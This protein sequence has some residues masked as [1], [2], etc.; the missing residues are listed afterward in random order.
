MFQDENED[1]GTDIY[2]FLWKWKRLEKVV[3]SIPTFEGI[4]T[5]MDEKWDT[6]FDLWLKVEP[7]DDYISRRR[8]LEMVKKVGFIDE[9]TLS[10]LNY[11]MVIESPFSSRVFF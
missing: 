3:F 10:N 9:S 5:A 1:G 6:E 2:N 7:M 4:G 8:T 11:R